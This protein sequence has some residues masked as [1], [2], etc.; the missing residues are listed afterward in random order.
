MLFAMFTCFVLFGREEHQVVTQEI[1]TC[2]RVMFGVGVAL[3]EVGVA[4]F[5]VGVAFALTP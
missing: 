5:E 2:V 1:Q 3:F 4:L